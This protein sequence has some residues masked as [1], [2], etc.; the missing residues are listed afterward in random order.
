MAA[1]SSWAGAIV[2]AGFPIPVKA[3]NLI[4]SGSKDGFKTLCVCHSQPIKQQN[5]C[6]ID[7]TVVTDTRKGVE[8]SKD[9]FH[10]LDDKTV[11]AIN[12]VGKSDAL[13]PELI[14]P[15]NTLDLH[16]ATGAFRILPDSKAGADKPVAILWR[17]L[18]KTGLAIVTRWTPRAGSKDG[19]IAIYAGPDG[20]YANTLPFEHQLSAAP[21]G[22]SASIAVADAEL[23]MFEQAMTTLYTVG[24]YEAAAFVSDHNARRTAAINA[25]VA[26]A[27]LP[28]AA[29]APSA[30]VPDLM[31]ALAASLS[32]AGATPVQG[33]P[34]QTSDQEPIPA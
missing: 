21:K 23:A 2:F 9:H 8:L 22:E 3:Y 13:E 10:S 33:V 31:A 6:A 30:A 19:I 16:L 12:G 14:A 24:P 29:E 18:S 17:T 11:E 32:A 28:A 20:L 1:R 15:V 26:G 27:P 34:V 5:A 25:A 4:G 7:G